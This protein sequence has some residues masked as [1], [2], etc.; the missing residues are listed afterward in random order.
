MEPVE[1]RVLN[2][3]KEIATYLHVCVRTAQRWS[4]KSAMPVHHPT[5][6]GR[7]S[8]F[9]IASELDA[10]VTGVPARQQPSDAHFR[11]TAERTRELLEA[12]ERIWTEVEFHRNLL[13]ATIEQFQVSVRRLSSTRLRE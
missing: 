9:A 13:A 5:G 4:K 3:W 7:G 8:V 12:S 10:W 1:P 2:S 6:Q 11:T